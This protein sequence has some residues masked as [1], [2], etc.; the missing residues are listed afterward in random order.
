MPDLFSWINGRINS[1]VQAAE[2]LLPKL[3]QAFRG[4]H[5]EVPDDL[6][7]TANGLVY[8]PGKPQLDY[9]WFEVTAR[10]GGKAYHEYRAMRLMHLASI[11][12]NAR[13]DQGALAKMRT[14]LRGLYNAKV[15][16]VYLVAGIYHPERLGIVQCYGAVGRG[17]T[18]TDAAAQA[19]HGAASLE[20]A[21]A[22]A[23]PQV[24]FHPLNIDVSEWVSRA[25]MR[26]PYSVLAIGHPDP[27][28]NA[29]GGQSDL[30]PL[31]SSG[32]HGVQE[33]TLQQ[34]ELVM[35]GMAQLEEDFL[36]QVLLTPVSMQSASRMLSGLAEYTSTWAAWQS[37]SR[38]F[39][40]GT[41]LP[42]MLTGAI[43]RNAGTGYT[44]SQAAGTA[45]GTSHVA[46]QSQTDGSAHS[47][48]EGVAVTNGIS[49]THTEGTAVTESHT[50][51][52]G[53]SAGVNQSQTQGEGWNVGG[54]VGVPGVASVNGG[55]NSFSS[56]SQGSFAST[57]NTV[58]DGTAVTHSVSDSVTS[59]HSE[60]QSQSDTDTT[61][62]AD[63]VGAADG[64]SHTDSQS[65]GQALSRGLSQGFS[66]GIAFGIA[67]SFSVGEANQWQF[68]P[69]ILLTNILRRQQEI[70]NTITL[71][72]GFYTDVYALAGTERGRQALLTLIPE[73]FHGTEDVVTGVQTRTLTPEEDQYLRL[74]AKAMVPSTR[75]IHL[76]E[77]MTAYADSTLL[78]MLQ[79][80]AYMAPGLFEEGLART[81][82]EAIPP[83]AFDPHMAGEVALARQYS[84][85]RGAL[86]HSILRLTP[87]RHFHTAFVGDT[88]FGK[89]VAAERLAFET[90]LHWHYRTI[91]LDFGQGWRKAFHWPGLEGRVD[92]RQLHPGGVRP[93]RWNPLQIPKRIDPV[94]YRNLVCEL[95]A[96]AG[97]MGPRQ[98]GFLRDRLTHLYQVFGVL[99]PDNRT[100]FER[101]TSKK[102]GEED[103]NALIKW[104][105][106]FD[107]T[108]ED[109]IN[110]ARKERGAPERKTR[111]LEL[112]DLEPFERQALA[113]YRSQKV[114]LG[115]WVSLLRGLFIRLGEKD[116]ASRSSLQGVL[117]RLE[118]L[119]EGEMQ[120]MYGMGQDT[121]AV[122]DLGLLGPSN[123]PWGVTV[124]EGGAEMDEFSK[125]ALLSL[126]ASILY[127]DAV[128]RRRE[129]LSGAK[130][131]P[132]QIIFEAANKVLSGVA[133]GSASDR[134]GSSADQTAQIFLDMWRDGRKYKCFLHVLAQSV[135]ELPTGILSSCNNGFFG[136][137]KNDRDRQAV[138]AHIARNT[139]GF[140]NSEYDRFIARMP[141]GMA[142]AKLGYTADMLQTEPYLVEPLL[143]PARE[144]SD[145]EINHQFNPSA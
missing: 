65:A 96:N 94:R 99:P 114:S 54:S 5:L 116:Q 125:S 63:T 113:V 104:T 58:S 47:H 17:E 144:P 37:G 88:G 103:G 140:V 49:N 15:D 115:D 82:Q 72:G 12:L 76:P 91:V 46:S 70:L 10:E 69:A 73:A 126:A 95:F 71:E 33:F 25:L 101:D 92:I 27:R 120:R 90:T 7:V 141:V 139:K 24:R 39:N 66:Q 134:D 13:G 16:I 45:D 64:V 68:D 132:M 4:A 130:F 31:L 84:T 109:M 2:A 112:V 85:E 62:H 118:P 60:T 145:Q 20:A 74:H 121:I 111:G 105:Y 40:I 51:S 128:V 52:V 29:R 56:E 30:N 57:S 78:T 93:I 129:T 97:R 44:E 133:V 110:L 119:A 36:L 41:S 127:L 18:L 67:P 123:A 42:L 53:Q 83:F 89:S 86:S 98:L 100:I 50:E 143:L 19:I 108:E 79:A 137:T 48:T 142:I 136:Q 14:V 1:A 21:M 23:Y 55:Y 117:L 26:M 61:S 131:P 3:E 32:K 138:L 80:A 22:A 9:L 135:S 8:A 106:V 34:N 87:E 81:V 124:I 28:E 59:S 11:P 75:E 38:S 122:E 35:R 6:D 77:A 43:A 107:D 102:K